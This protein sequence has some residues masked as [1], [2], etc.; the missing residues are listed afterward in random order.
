MKKFIKSRKGMTYV[1]LLVA[2]SVLVLI[3][4]V[5]SPMLLNAY[6]SLYNAGEMTIDTYNAK[7]KIE[8]G[9][10]I[11]EDDTI[12]E[13]IGVSYKQFAAN[14]YLNMRQVGD[15]I[16]DLETIYG[17][18][19][20]R[21]QIMT[22]SVM[23]DD[24]QSYAIVLHLV[25]I[26]VS[27]DGSG[28][29][30]I[31][32]P[33]V[34]GK[35]QEGKVV[36]KV[37]CPVDKSINFQYGTDYTFDTSALAAKKNYF[38]ILIPKADISYSPFYIQVYYYD[39]ND[40]PKYVEK[41]IYIS[42]P[43]MMF[44]GKSTTNAEYLTATG[45]DENGALL[46][47]G[48]KM[49]VGGNYITDPT[50]SNGQ[51]INKVRYIE[52]NDA[53]ITN[54]NGSY[55][56]VGDNSFVR[57][58]W[59]I[60]EAAAKEITN[61]AADFF[62]KANYVVATGSS[63]NYYKKYWS[64]DYVASDLRCSNGETVVIS[65]SDGAVF[66]KNGNKIKASSVDS[67]FNDATQYVAQISYVR[68]D[69]A[70]RAAALT[71][72]GAWFSNN[73]TTSKIF[74]ANGQSGQERDPVY[75]RDIMIRC[76]WVYNDGNAL[77]YGRDNDYSY[78]ATSGSIKNKL[79]T[80]CNCLRYE[81]AE[82]SLNGKN[83]VNRSKIN[84]VDV[85][86]RN[87]S[88]YAYDNASLYGY[89]PFVFF[90]YDGTPEHVDRFYLCTNN[91]WGSELSDVVYDAYGYKKFLGL[92]TSVDSGRRTTT[93]QLAWLVTT[94]SGQ[95]NPPGCPPREN[96]SDDLNVS[97]PLNHEALFNFHS[98]N[99]TNSSLT[100]YSLP[101]WNKDWGSNYNHS[102]YICDRAA[103]F[104]TSLIGYEFKPYSN[105]SMTNLNWSAHTI[106]STSDIQ[107]FNENQKTV[108]DF[109]GDYFAM[110]SA[111]T[112]LAATSGAYIG[113]QSGSLTKDEQLASLRIKAYGNLNISFNAPSNIAG[114]S[115]L[116]SNSVLKKMTSETS[117]VNGAPYSEVS[118]TDVCS[119]T[120]SKTAE[121]VYSGVTPAAAVVYGP[122]MESAHSDNGD[123]S[124]P[125]S[126]YNIYLIQ[127]NGDEGYV[128]RFNEAYN[129]HFNYDIFSTIPAATSV[130]YSDDA[131]FT[132]GY[133]SNRDL[134]YKCLASNNSLA[135][136]NAQS[137]NTR[138]Y[139]PKDFNNITTYEKFGE[140]TFGVGYR[141]SGQS[142]VTVRKEDDCRSAAVTGDHIIDLTDMD[143][144][145]NSDNFHKFTLNNDGNTCLQLTTLMNGSGTQ[146]NTDNTNGTSN[147]TAFF[148]E[149]H[150]GVEYKV[151]S[152]YP[153][154]AAA[155]TSLSTKKNSGAVQDTGIIEY[156]LAGT[157]SAVQFNVSFTS[158]APANYK[159]TSVAI[160]NTDGGTA[161]GSG[162]IDGM[163]VF[164][165][166]SNGKVYTG[167]I[168]VNNETGLITSNNLALSEIAAINKF[169]TVRSVS[170]YEA[171]EAQK[172]LVFAS[173]T[174]NDGKTHIAYSLDGGSNWS[175]YSDA[176]NYSIY[177]VKVVGGYVYAAG[178]S[179]NDTTGVVLHN[180]VIADE[181][182]GTV[183]LGTS[184]KA[185]T[186]YY[187]S[188][189]FSAE[190]KASGSGS[191]A[192]LPPIYSFASKSA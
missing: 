97:H 180:S 79:N 22:D 137:S 128:V 55:I 26:N 156:Q 38:S 184:W 61:K 27:K 92:A 77:G 73:N 142:D 141:V 118:L 134:V 190:G 46:I 75:N 49:K 3:V 107:K 170:C 53:D 12:L 131:S 29:Y 178:A 76:N 42:A 81:D 8:K 10:S 132:L 145:F 40:N 23:S 91:N 147:M 5:F 150:S 69:L 39:D 50:I 125:A 127:S 6:T 83:Y 103:N 158:T 17:V 68:S 111:K 14:L 183:S 96:Q 37:S 120:T 176:N 44:V 146:V 36:V 161:D 41:Y 148:F 89:V 151:I 18:G 117:E 152:D 106:S 34:S 4:F 78:V 163:R 11:R 56:M 182:H 140:Y 90:S 64:G 52:A 153:T 144:I 105:S 59:D 93:T 143:S 130:T 87:H 136:S 168:K 116:Y 187:T 48:R 60:D 7:S 138:L 47:A 2:F 129:N 13:D 185:T 166:A 154:C 98:N 15:S 88:S 157:D 43:N 124:S 101:G 162:N 1:E 110:D 119:F 70:S 108:A 94:D 188:F 115:T 9:L 74:L 177:D 19:G 171:V 191:G 149:K 126:K 85:F 31:V 67:R 123:Q 159:F 139:Y 104:S 165:G 192:N 63:T 95:V 133:C 179:S 62:I 121:I 21:I 58:L 71:S 173:G 51:V 99:R 167:T 65:L 169:S 172:T 102:C 33:D 86:G 160:M 100:W 122:Y 57:R 72:P 54:A 113:R 109:I 181:E 175:D 82:A 186:K 28:N 20:G 25:N 80:Y 32:G 114:S 155:Y 112:Q 135:V 66:T 84:A 16:S 189:S 30:N 45:V 174:S 24:R 35:W 164:I